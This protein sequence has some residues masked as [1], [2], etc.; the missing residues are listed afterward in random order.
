MDEQRR[1]CAQI[2]RSSHRGISWNSNQVHNGILKAAMPE[3]TTAARP[4]GLIAKIARRAGVALTISIAVAFLMLHSGWRGGP[5]LR[6][7]IVGLSATTS[8]TLFELVPPT[9]PP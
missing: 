1:S 7:I 4:A 5:F 8:F 9:L 6:T 3:L 2:R